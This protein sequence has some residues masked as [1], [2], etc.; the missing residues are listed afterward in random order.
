[1]QTFKQSYFKYFG[2]SVGDWGDLNFFFFTLSLQSNYLIYTSF[3]IIFPVTKLDKCKTKGPSLFYGFKIVSLFT[4]DFVIH[5]FIYIYIYIY[6]PL[7]T[8]RK[9]LKVNIWWS[10][11]GLNSEFSFS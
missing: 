4:N 8:C 9:L 1:M 10:L 5:F 11:T 3:L 2:G 6:I 7:R